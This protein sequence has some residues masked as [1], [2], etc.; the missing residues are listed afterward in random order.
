MPTVFLCHSSKDKP[1]VRGLAAELT[2]QAIDVWIDEKEINVGDYLAERVSKGISDSKFMVV[3][4]SRNSVDSRWVQVEMNKGMSKEIED[5]RT[6]VLPIVIDDCQIPPVL[7]GKVYA[8]FRSPS[9]FEE[10]FRLL[11]RAIGISELPEAIS[12]P[13]ASEATTG[14]ASQVQVVKH[15]EDVLHYFPDITVLGVDRGNVKRIDDVGGGLAL[16]DVPFI[17][18]VTPPAGWKSIFDEERAHPRHTMWRKARV[19]EDRIVVRCALYEVRQYHFDDIR[20]DV[21]ASNQKYR[22]SLVKQER[23]YRD[24]VRQESDEQERIDDALEGLD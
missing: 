22:D 13:Q 6:V 1:F 12:N 20:Q 17:L 4:L 23:E 21:A 3:V 5:R 15:P 10:P 19:E 9:D 8:D 24:R 14:L 2:K 16:Y 11:L 18:S 7:Q